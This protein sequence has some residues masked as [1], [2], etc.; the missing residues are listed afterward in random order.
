MTIFRILDISQDNLWGELVQL[1]VIWFDLLSKVSVCFLALLYVCASVLEIWLVGDDEYDIGSDGLSVVVWL[2]DGWSA[3]LVGGDIGI[4][5]CDVFSWMISGE[6]ELDSLEWCVMSVE[7][8]FCCEPHEV[9]EIDRDF[10][11]LCVIYVML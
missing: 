3:I 5:V 8:S 2:G 9:V 4:S 1:D 7:P 11:F 6:D 10:H